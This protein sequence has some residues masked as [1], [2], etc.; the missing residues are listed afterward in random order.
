MNKTNGEVLLNDNTI[1]EISV[2]SLPEKYNYSFKDP[3]SIEVI[4]DYLINL[5]LSSNFNENPN[6][7]VGM[8]WVIDIKCTDGSEYEIYH[9]GNM[10]ISSNNSSWY[11]MKHDE[12]IQF[13]RLLEK[14]EE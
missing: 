1:S 3:K 6:D 8:T 2:T 14:L 4:E 10:F 13:D 7:Y 5:H 12:A 11:K 9:F